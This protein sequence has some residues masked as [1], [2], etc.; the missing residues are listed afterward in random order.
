MD[1]G[2]TNQQKI[3]TLTDIKNNLQIELY[4]LLVRLGI[5]PEEFTEEDAIA[6]EDSFIGEKA[7]IRTILAAVSMI[8]GKL[9]E[10]S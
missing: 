7:R 10:L 6:T 9:T 3:A 8:D 4:T 2:L 1:F 5:D